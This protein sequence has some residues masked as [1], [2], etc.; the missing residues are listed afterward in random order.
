MMTLNDYQDGAM[1]TAIFPTSVAEMYTALKLNG[2]A[3]EVAEKVGKCLRDHKGV[4]NRERR[5][6]IALELGDVLWYVAALADVLG[7]TLEEIAQMNQEKL[8]DRYAR[9]KMSGSGDNR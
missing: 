2:E 6:A 5:E 7:F 1:A 8:A 9:G 4:F 3:G